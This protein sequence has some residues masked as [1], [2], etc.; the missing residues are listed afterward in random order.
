MLNKIIKTQIKLTIKFLLHVET[1]DIKTLI[2][3]TLNIMSVNSTPSAE[4]HDISQHA[5]EPIL[6]LNKIFY[7]CGKCSIEVK[8]EPSVM[9]FLCSLWFHNKCVKM[10]QTVFKALGQNGGNLEFICKC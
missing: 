8:E 3:I 1:N 10:T 4:K 2:F 7:Q 9:C 5:N 6:N